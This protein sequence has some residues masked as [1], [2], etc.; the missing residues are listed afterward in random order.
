MKI[1]LK[2]KRKKLKLFLGAQKLFPR[3]LGIT[4]VSPTDVQIHC[5]ELNCEYKMKQRQESFLSFSSILTQPGCENT[6]PT[7]LQWKQYLE[8]LDQREG[9]RSSAMSTIR[10]WEIKLK[11]DCQS[12]HCVQEGFLKTSFQS[13]LQLALAL[14]NVYHELCGGL[15]D[16]SA[17]TVWRRSM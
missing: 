9:D 11:R 3:D 2:N 10:F 5:W 1:K 14:R 12:V 7:S 15:Q 17:T 13:A 16:L 4:F 6:A 8:G